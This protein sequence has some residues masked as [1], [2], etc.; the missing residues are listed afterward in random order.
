MVYG[1]QISRLTRMIGKL[2]RNIITSVSDLREIIQKHKQATHKSANAIQKQQTPPE[3]SSLL[4]TVKAIS[5]DYRTSQQSQES[6][7]K[8]TLWV[9]VAGVLVVAAYTT[10]A[11][12]QGCST[13]N[14]VTIANKTF[15]AAN[16]PYVGVS[17]IDVA[18]VEIRPTVAPNTNQPQTTEP[19]MLF[20]HVEI[21]NFGP[22]PG[23][24]FLVRWR[25]LLS[26][27]N[28]PFDKI[29]EL[30]STIFPTQPVSLFGH[31]G[32][33]DYPAIMSGEK[34]LAVEVTIEYEGPS[35]H[36]KECSK[37]QYDSR[38]NAFLDLGPMCS[39]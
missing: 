12:W 34:T 20:F 1:L 36:Y 24:N 10:V 4:N 33:R 8:K 19:N 13:R 27:I 16:R 25:I 35:G 3:I 9:S 31:A 6:Y 21:K 7:H 30:P 17:K 15:E 37:H 22:V 23:T 5:S 39:N 28:Q 29:P 26:G 2:F 38:F 14:L 11:L 32:R 18:P